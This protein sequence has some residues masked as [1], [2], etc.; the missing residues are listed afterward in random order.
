M[1]FIPV[2]ATLTFAAQET[3]ISIFKT[4]ALLN[5]L[6]ETIIIHFFRILYDSKELLFYINVKIFTV[7]F[8]NSVH[9]Y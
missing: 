2:L 9:H 6:V 8:D 3:L 1:Q 4:V 7:T 5:I